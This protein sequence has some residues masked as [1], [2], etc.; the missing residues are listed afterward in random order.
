MT[1][2]KFTF[3]PTLDSHDLYEAINVYLTHAYGQT[4]EL[5]EQISKLLPKKSEFDPKTWI[6]S[7]MVERNPE[8]SSFEEVKTA[9]FR[10]GNM[11]YPNMKLR[12][13]KVPNENF[14]LLSVDSHDAIL[15]APEGSPDHAMLEQLK[16]ANAEIANKIQTQWDEMGLPTDRN[17]M[18]YKIEQA[19]AN[20]KG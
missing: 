7:D 5:P 2:K 4:E 11:F 6:M 19:K 1:E 12:L 17:Y 9:S 16:A 18:R 8:D 14:F 15:H 10:L 13:A 3:K 20:K